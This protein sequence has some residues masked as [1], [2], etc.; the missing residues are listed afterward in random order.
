MY[1][2]IYILTNTTYQNMYAYACVC[3]RVCERESLCV[4]V[5]VCVCLRMC[6]C[7]CVFLACYMCTNELLAWI[8]L[9]KEGITWQL[10]GK[11]MRVS[12]DLKERRCDLLLTCACVGASLF[13]WVYVENRMWG[14]ARERVRQQERVRVSCASW[15]SRSAWRSLWRPHHLQYSIHGY[16]VIHE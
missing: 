12:L 16:R 7:T 5:C 15:R 4:C 11:K 8:A 9:G 6:T 14:G 13:L 10:N 2:Y 3:V 1:V